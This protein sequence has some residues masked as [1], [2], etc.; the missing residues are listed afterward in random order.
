MT[1]QLYLSKAE[2]SIVNTNSKIIYIYP[3]D[4]DK[5]RVKFVWF[6]SDSIYYTYHNSEQKLSL[7]LDD[8]HLIKSSYRKVVF[9]Y[10][11]YNE[12][13]NINKISEA[14]EPKELK[15]KNTPE[16][17]KDIFLS[18]LQN[19]SITCEFDKTFRYPYLS[20]GL[21][22]MLPSAGH[23]YIGEWKKSKRFLVLEGIGLGC[24]VASKFMYEDKPY[25]YGDFYIEK[26]N[27]S[28]SG[29]AL[30][31]TGI[32][33]YY[34][35]RLWEYNN[36]YQLT[37]NKYPITNSKKYFPTL[38]SV[39]YGIAFQNSEDDFNVKDN[40]FKMFNSIYIRSNLGKNTGLLVE[41]GKNTYALNFEKFEKMQGKLKW[42]LNFGYRYNSSYNI[43]SPQIGY[44]WEL[45]NKLFVSGHR[46]FYSFFY[47]EKSELKT[48]TEACF[49]F[50][51][52]L[53]IGYHFEFV[54]IYIGGRIQITGKQLQEKEASAYT[55]YQSNV[56]T[57]LIIDQTQE[58]GIG[59]RINF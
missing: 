47:K 18:E 19:D 46:D 21:A 35:T 33:I 5:I 9:N 34:G 6:K 59:F 28:G 51:G 44:T 17:K 56:T 20:V 22:M 39:D 13:K 45:G 38:S 40:Q 10:D 7:A 30:L 42:S 41:Y 57:T 53:S 52:S 36:V 37:K 14:I 49:I 55:G 31:A 27:I 48:T 4:S 29:A 58:M 24:I 16:R 3:K 25:D 23:L 1:Q 2:N 26:S 43:H 15:D 32:I 11:R 50:P 8:I 54:D 12:L